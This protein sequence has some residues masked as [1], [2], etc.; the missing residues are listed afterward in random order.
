LSGAAHQAG[1]AQGQ[2]APYVTEDRRRRVD[3]LVAVQQR[4]GQTQARGE[5]WFTALPVWRPRRDLASSVLRAGALQ[6]YGV[7]KVVS[8]GAEGHSSPVDRFQEHQQVCLLCRGQR[9]R[10]RGRRRENLPIRP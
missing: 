8:L 1:A 9:V 7:S 4:R 2:V 3:V 5:L 6:P 10:N